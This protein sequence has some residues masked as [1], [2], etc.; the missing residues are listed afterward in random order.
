[1]GAGTRGGAVRFGVT[2]A[3]EG[4]QG[5]KLLSLEGTKTPKGGL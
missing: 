4:G 5:W 1:M 3:P 2:P